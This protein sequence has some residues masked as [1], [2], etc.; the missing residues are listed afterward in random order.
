[1]DYQRRRLA[2]S[3]TKFEEKQ[4]QNGSNAPLN[5][6]GQSWGQAKLYEPLAPWQTRLVQLIGCRT[7]DNEGSSAAKPAFELRVVKVD[8]ADME[9]VGITGTADVVHYTAVSHVW[10]SAPSTDEVICNGRPLVISSNL[11]II[12]SRLAPDEGSVY[13]WVNALC[14]NQGDPAE[15]AAQVRNI[16]RIFK[17]AKEVIG[18]ISD[19][20]YSPIL[21][22][23][24]TES[25]VLA[26]AR[27]GQECQEG[28]LALKATLFMLE[29]SNL[30]KRTWI[31]HEIFA[32]RHMR[33]ISA[34]PTGQG[35]EFNELWSAMHLWEGVGIRDDGWAE[36]KVQEKQETPKRASSCFWLMAQHYQ[37]AGTDR[38]DF[39][40]PQAR[41]RYSIHWLRILRQGAQFEVTDE[42]DRIYGVFGMIWS[43]ASRFYVESRPDIKPAEFP[44]DY[45]K[46]VSKVFQDVIKFLINTDRNLD[47][48][49]VFENRGFKTQDLPTWVTDWRRPQPRSLLHKE[50][51][52]VLDEQTYGVPPQQDLR[53]IGRLT[54]MRMRLFIVYELSGYDPFT[55]EG[56]LKEQRLQPT[57]RRVCPST[58]GKGQIGNPGRSGRRS[59]QRARCSLSVLSSLPVRRRLPRKS[60]EDCIRAV[61]DHD[62]RRDCFSE[63]WTFSLRVKFC[64]SRPVG[65]SRTCNRLG[66]AMAGFG[67]PILLC[68]KQ[69]R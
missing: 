42:R 38:H 9:G 29:N 30:W 68:P 19:A 56:I 34:N 50:P 11:A 55:F 7:I 23:S 25:D 18:W 60:V 61:N 39:A 63:R 26:N 8:F 33:L 27:H 57:T 45:T 13:L 22:L 1:M 51:A 52:R 66:C 65:V 35:L 54:L 15:K 17:K 37:H 3:K 14:I 32:A 31:R 69:N 6:R 46:S 58:E 62:R 2:T 4:P 21:L 28:L 12:F 49:L 43:P 24:A 64:L 20:T 40:F 47:C 59:R 48:L 41:L 5:A 16:M 53:D 67:L 44:I 10:G 36:Q